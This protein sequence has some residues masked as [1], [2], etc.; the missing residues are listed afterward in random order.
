MIIDCVTCTSTGSTPASAPRQRCGCCRNSCDDS[1]TTRSGSR[2]VGSSTCCAA[3]SRAPLQ[4]RQPTAADHDGG[5]RR[6]TSAV[7]CRSN[8][9]STRR[10]SA[11]DLDGRW[12]SRRGEFDASALLDQMLRRPRRAGR[13]HPAALRRAQA[14]SGSVRS[15]KAI[16]SSQGLA[17]LI[18][19]LSLQ[20]SGVRVVFD[21]ESAVSRSLGIWRST[22]YRRRPIR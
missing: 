19:Y 1:S 3:S 4:L 22:A 6:C 5:R 14:R 17:E 11:L 9:R 7:V 15:S 18:G 20:R 12:S 21:E 8:A 13:D 16:P 2:I 10:R